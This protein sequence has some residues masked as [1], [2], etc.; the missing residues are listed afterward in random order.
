MCDLVT[1]QSTIPTEKTPKPQPLIISTPQPAVIAEHH[2]IPPVSTTV[3]H[4]PFP[5]PKAVEPKSKAAS[6]FQHKTHYYREV[7]PSK[8]Q[9]LS[10]IPAQHRKVVQQITAKHH[11]TWRSLISPDYAKNDFVGH[12]I[13]APGHF[14]SILSSPEKPNDFILFDSK[15]GRL[16]H[17]WRKEILHYTY[18]PDAE[19]EKPVR[20]VVLFMPVKDDMDQNPLVNWTSRLMWIPENKP[21]IMADKVKLEETEV[22][23]F[24]G[25]NIIS[26]MLT[27]HKDVSTQARVPD[28]LQPGIV[29]AQGGGCEESRMATGLA[30]L[31]AVHGYAFLSFK[32]RGCGDSS[33]NFIHSTPQQ[34]AS[35]I[36]TAHEF[37]SQ[38]EGVDAHRIGIWGTQEGFLPALIACA[39]SPQNPKCVLTVLSPQCIESAENAKIKPLL[40]QPSLVIAAHD[41]MPRVHDFLATQPEAEFVA[42][43]CSC[44]NKTADSF[45]NPP[46]LDQLAPVLAGAVSSWLKKIGN[47]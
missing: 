33:G 7:A 1:L 25:D 17:L 30:R 47:R 23:F 36:L 19:H 32:A 4:P 35:D 46:N 40:K 31:M 21:A 3:P 44:S 6:K 2:L 28:K 5:R 34:I 38:T 13:V 10:D 9:S 8:Q 15:S 16:H 43:D 12:Y 45:S 22:V 18:G 11:M 20:G 27:R 39:E 24:N 26:G 41:I 14:V 29:W 37:L 42:I